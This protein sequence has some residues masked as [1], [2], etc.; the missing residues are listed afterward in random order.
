MNEI[1]KTTIS[2]I[3][4]LANQ[5][6]E[7]GEELRRNLAVSS[8]GTIC[9]ANGKIDD[10]YE[11]CIEKVVKRQAREFYANFPLSIIT[12]TLIEDFCR[13]ESF[14]RKDNFGDFCLSLYQQ[15]ECITNRI[16]LNRDLSTIVEKM[17]WLPAYVKSGNGIELTIEN[18]SEGN[19]TIAALLFPGQNKETG[20][21]NSIKKSRTTLQSQY[22]L[23][24]IRIVVYFLGYKGM[25]KNS[26]YDSFREFTSVL[27]DIYAC[28]NM[29]HRGNTRTPW[30]LEIFDRVFSQKGIY[31]LKFLGALT[32]YIDCVK[33]GYSQIQKMLEYAEGVKPQPIQSP[34]PKVLG[35]IELPDDAKKRFKKS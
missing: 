35:K 23:D 2:K 30:E 20:E 9:V 4:K 28:R 10:I 17:V 16:C 18:R 19:Y 26:D 14:H 25:M 5:N 3:V 34:S 1:F 13:M 29:N 11:Y 22:A 32:E 12:E 21:L 15:I 31:Y 6:A 8:D 33:K 27:S 7:F 24:K